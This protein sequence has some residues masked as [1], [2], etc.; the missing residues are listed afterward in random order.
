METSV[1]SQQKVKPSREI[2]ENINRGITL[3]RDV[4]QDTTLN[5]ANTGITKE[6]RNVIPYL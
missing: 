4:R 5:T 6:R 1:K 2:K 3:E